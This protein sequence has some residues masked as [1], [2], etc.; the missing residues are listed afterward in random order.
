MHQGCCLRAAAAETCQCR[1]SQPLGLRV[2]CFPWLQDCVRLEVRNLEAW[3]LHEQSCCARTMRACCT[4]FLYLR[5]FD[6]DWHLASNLGR[7]S[8]AMG[9]H[10]LGGDCKGAAEKLLETMMARIVEVTRPGV[11]RNLVLSFMKPRET[12]VTGFLQIWVSLLSMPVKEAV[13]CLIVNPRA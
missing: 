9:L 12:C 8:L 1:S 11:D 10:S 13:L 5:G 7:V 3:I 2:S 4:G 6:N